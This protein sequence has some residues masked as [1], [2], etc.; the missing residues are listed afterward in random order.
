[1]YRANMLL[2]LL[3]VSCSLVTFADAQDKKKN[4][5]VSGT[6]RYEYELEGQTRK[7]TLKLNVTKDGQV[8]GSYT[9][10][11][12]DAIEL[13]SG[14]VEG[15]NLAL[16]LAL[17]YQGTPVKVKYNGKIKDDDIVGKVVA[18]TGE[19]D[20]EFDWTAK[21]SVEASDIVGLWELEIDAGDNVLEPK[22]E[23]KLDGKDLK[24]DYKDTNTNLQVNIDKLRIEKNV[25]KFTINA[26]LDGAD[27]KADFS[28]RPYGNKISGTVAYDLAGQSGEVEFKGALK[29]PKKESDKPVAPAK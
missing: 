8:T 19:G 2:S 20:M 13:T 10:V 4:A 21:R 3:I 6:W 9:G 28:G 22:L 5:D 12:K 1:M 7:D 29:A 16:E 14:K 24:G 27:L 11:S 15:D 18:T 26:K 17:T 23:I 25:V